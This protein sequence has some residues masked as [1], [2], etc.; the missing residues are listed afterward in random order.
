MYGFKI[1]F[2]AF[3]GSG[4]YSDSSI[5]PF[6]SKKFD[7][8]I[9]ISTGQECIPLKNANELY[10]SSNGFK[11][12]EEAEHIS[13]IATQSLII[14]SALLD[15]GLDIPRFSIKS[16]LGKSLVESLKNESVI[17]LNDNFGTNIY[18]YEEG[19]EIKLFKI[20]GNPVILCNVEKFSHYFSHS[21]NK[22]ILNQN[23]LLGLKIINETKQMSNILSRYVLIMSSIEC[24]SKTLPVS[25]TTQ[26]KINSLIK[27]IKNA[28]DWPEKQN[29][30]SA[31]GKLK[32]ESIS[33]ACVRMMSNVLGNEKGKLFKFH[34]N[35]RSNIIHEGIMPANFDVGREEPQLR[36]LIIEFYEG[37]IAIEAEP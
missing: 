22:S 9:K 4:I 24:V 21:L 31:L 1:K 27:N 37:L 7:C 35:N 10:L 5:L 3:K 8:E 33:Q 6:I 36:R 2:K 32:K 16:F 14:T 17:V 26:I 18:E 12:A 29:L 20:T 19:Q 30:M 13:T 28:D 15:L 11:S 23:I 34:Y 25:T